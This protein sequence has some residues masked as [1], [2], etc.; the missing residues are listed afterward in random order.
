MYGL[1]M[2]GIL[3]AVVL[4]VALYGVLKCLADLIVGALPPI[5]KDDKKDKK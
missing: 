2:I 1:R 4:L 3:L 5:F